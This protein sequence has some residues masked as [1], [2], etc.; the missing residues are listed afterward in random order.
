M[1]RET[2]YRSVP[3]V[4]L[5]VSEPSTLD[6]VAT[7]LRGEGMGLAVALGERGCLRVATAV[8]PDIILL[9]P[10]LSRGLLS[11]LRVHPDSRH[12]QTS[13]SQALAG[14]TGSETAPTTRNSQAE[15]R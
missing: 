10:R 6:A 2:A 1:D 4:L 8:S 14:R 9:D 15:S 5:G 12:A 11:L 13:W 7:Q 3:L